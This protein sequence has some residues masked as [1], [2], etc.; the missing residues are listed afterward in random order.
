MLMPMP[1]RGAQPGPAAPMQV[2]AVP[3]CEPFRGY[4]MRERRSPLATAGRAPLVRRLRAG[5]AMSTACSLS[6]SI[7]LVRGPA[8]LLSSACCMAAWATGATG[9]FWPLLQGPAGGC[10]PAPQF[11]EPRGRRVAR[12]SAAAACC[13]CCWA[14]RAAGCRTT[15]SA[16]GVLWLPERA[17]PARRQSAGLRAPAAVPSPAAQL[18]SR[19]AGAAASVEPGLA[20]RIEAQARQGRAK[21]RRAARCRRGAS[22][23]HAPSSLEQDLAREQATLERLASELPSADAAQQ[24]WPA[25]CCWTSRTDLPGRWLK[26]GDVVG[27]V[28]QRRRAAGARGGAAG[29]V[30]RG[31][32]CTRARSSVRLPQ[33]W[34]RAAGR[35]SCA[36]CPAAARELPSAALG[37]GRRR[38]ASRSTRAT[39]GV[40]TTLESVFEF[41]LELPARVGP[42]GYLGSRVP[43]WPSSIRPSR[44]AGR[45]CALVRR[46]LLSHFEV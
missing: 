28:R 15:P 45:C 27:Y 5:G 21:C 37:D 20:A 13:C 19:R 6:L 12:C 35:R 38:S 24:P 33:A 31:A 16:E 40:M 18:S 9:I 11:A 41:E 42:I 8:V 2:L 10:S 4:G 34:A 30:R 23:R 3:D 25:R 32:G 39:R 43:T 36:Q 44:W 46:Q 14:V 17:D 26:K 1:G 29:R 22:R 7:A